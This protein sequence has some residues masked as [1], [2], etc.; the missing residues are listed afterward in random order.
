[1]RNKEPMGWSK[2]G[3]GE[4]EGAAAKNNKIKK[5]RKEI[6]CVFNW[7][8]LRRIAHFGIGVLQITNQEKGEHLFLKV[9]SLF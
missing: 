9:R 6:K 2:R 1:M 8:I 7:F 4:G 5:M 3:E